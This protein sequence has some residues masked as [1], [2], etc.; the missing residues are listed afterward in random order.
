MFPWHRHAVKSTSLHDY[1]LNRQSWQPV[2]WCW[3]QCLGTSL[4]QLLLQV[5]L[6]SPG[7]SILLMVLQIRH[8]YSC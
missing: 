7:A 8:I 3:M 5:R 4:Q 6:G 2:L 1:A